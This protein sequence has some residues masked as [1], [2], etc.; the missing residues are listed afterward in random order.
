MSDMR[1]RRDSTGDGRDGASGT[2]RGEKEA[3]GQ[4]SDE[5]ANAPDTDGPAL[6]DTSADGRRA[7]E[8]K[9]G[10]SRT[11]GKE[12]PGSGSDGVASDWSATEKVSTAD[13]ASSAPTSE[14][15]VSQQATAEFDDE[16]AGGAT[17]I[18]G[19]EDGTAS[20]GPEFDPASVQAT[21]W[22]EFG[23]SS[24][25]DDDLGSAGSDGRE[26]DGEGGGGTGGAGGGLLDEDSMEVREPFVEPP[27]DG[28]DVAVPDTPIG[29][30]GEGATVPGAT[31][32]VDHVVRA[33]PFDDHAD[34]SALSDP[35]HDDVGDVDD[36]IDVVSQI[37]TVEAGYAEMSD[38]SLD[39][40]LVEQI[41]TD[42]DVDIG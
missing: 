34:L 13:D 41:D 9:D 42:L 22:N 28:R 19:A 26:H 29:G 32:V 30:F 21:S 27:V 33:R 14:S 36:S 10:S 38:V 20:D 1:T 6:R 7:G 15:F 23:D 11:D 5:K 2:T 16:Q 40:D 37:A 24:D 3:D 18:S 8:A 12:P 17:D 4:R 31:G 35:S 39:A 25:L